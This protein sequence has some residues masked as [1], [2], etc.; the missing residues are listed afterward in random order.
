MIGIRQKTELGKALRASGTKQSELWF[1]ESVETIVSQDD[2]WLE[3]YR[4]LN[5]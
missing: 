4:G 2:K 1:C 5:G 3:R